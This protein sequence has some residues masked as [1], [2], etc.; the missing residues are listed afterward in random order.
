MLTES[1]LNNDGMIIRDQRPED[2]SFIYHSWLQSIWNDQEGLQRKKMKKDY[3]FAG[4]HYLIKNI[5]PLCEAKVI[6]QKIDPDH[7]LGFIVYE[8]NSDAMIYHYLFIKSVFRKYG[9]GAL[10]YHYVEK[11]YSPQ[12]YTY[13]NSYSSRFCSQLGLIYNPYLLYT[14]ERKEILWDILKK[15][16]VIR[17]TMKRY[18]NI[19][20]EYR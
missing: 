16:E 3:F 6:S 9:L 4:H 5:L 20:I 12:F 14:P 11:S 19:S 1:D 10:L 8:S 13:R 2:E 15:R 18:E 7:I 17:D